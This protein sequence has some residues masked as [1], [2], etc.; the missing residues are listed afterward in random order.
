M[1]IDLFTKHQ[2]GVKGITIVSLRTPIYL[3]AT[4]EGIGLINYRMRKLYFAYRSMVVCTNERL[5]INDANIC[6][7]IFIILCS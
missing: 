2:E 6:A 3:R 7:H 1:K 4:L 5:K